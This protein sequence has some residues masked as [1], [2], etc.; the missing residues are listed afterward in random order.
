MSTLEELSLPRVVLVVDADGADAR[1]GAAALTSVLAAT[2][3]AVGSLRLTAGDG[4]AVRQ[5]VTAVAGDHDVLVIDAAC[6]LL[7]PLD[8]RGGTLADVGTALRYK[9]VSTG[10]VLVTTGGRAAPNALALNAEALARRELPV[11]G[12]VVRAPQAVGEATSR[13]GLTAA[14]GAPLLAVL[15]ADPAS[16]DPSSLESQAALGFSSD[17]WETMAP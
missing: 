12:V 3:T 15:P 2:G 6:G 11:I 4:P 7:D 13:A 8:E 17:T 5:A 10:A 9:G 14:A 1:L 16:D